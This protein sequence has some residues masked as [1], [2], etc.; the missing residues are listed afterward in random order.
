MCVS[1][2]VVIVVV[3][4]VLVVSRLGSEFGEEDAL[5]GFLHDAAGA[6]GGEVE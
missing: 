6:V 2:V 1:D 3:V 4:L 5:F